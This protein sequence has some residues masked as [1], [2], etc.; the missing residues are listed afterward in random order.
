MV[1]QR[2]S[3]GLPST[4]HQAGC[5]GLSESPE[6]G[7]PWGVHFRKRHPSTDL[8]SLLLS[9]MAGQRQGWTKNTL[10]PRLLPA[11]TIVPSPPI[12]TLTELLILFPFCVSPS[13]ERHECEY[14]CVCVYMCLKIRVPHI[15][16][17]Y[18]IYQ[19]KQSQQVGEVG[20]WGKKDGDKR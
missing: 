15:T 4:L 2:G 8:Q 13:Q 5:L 11:S 12:G 17:A 9:H 20:E 18:S 3:S 7:W 19:T 14:S 10:Q 1:I 16:C 6:L